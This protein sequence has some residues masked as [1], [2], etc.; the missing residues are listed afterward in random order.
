MA[1]F[2]NTT[3]QLSSLKELYNDDSWVMKDLVYAGNPALALL[4]K[5]ESAD[6]AYI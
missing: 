6:G 3:N 5:D 2:A 4:P 1:I